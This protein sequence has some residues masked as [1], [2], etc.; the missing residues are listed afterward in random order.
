[1][2]KLVTV[3]DLGDVQVQMRNGYGPL[4]YLYLGRYLYLDFK[5]SATLSL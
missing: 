1:M 4:S 5:V 2:F 3:Q